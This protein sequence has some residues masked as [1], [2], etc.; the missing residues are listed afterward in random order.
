MKRLLIAVSCIAAI[1]VL[2][3]FVTK[4]WLE[5]VA[6]DEEFLKPTV[7]IPEPEIPYAGDVPLTPNVRPVIVVSGSD[8][9]MGYQWYRQ[10]VEIYGRQPLLERGGRQ[11]NPEEAEALKAWQW[12]IK[13]YTPEMENLLKGMVSAAKDAGI[14]MTYEQL[15][16]KWLPREYVVA[17]RHKQKLPPGLQVSQNAEECSDCAEESDCS[18]F[19]AWG[20]ATRDGRL[21]A[22]GSGDHEIIIGDNEIR[23]FEYMLLAIPESGNAYILSTSTGCCWHASMNN[24]GVTMF[25]HGATGYNMRYKKPE[26]QDFGYGVPNNMITMHVLRNAKSAQEAVDLVLSLPSPDDRIGGAWADVKGNAFVVE[27]RNNPRVVRKA[28]DHGERDF[29]YST[30]NNLSKLLSNTYEESPGKPI[31]YVEFAGWLGDQ[32]S[33]ESIPRNLSIRNLLHNYHGLVDRDFAEMMWRFGPDPAPRYKS[34]EQADEDFYKLQGRTW[35]SHIS[36]TGNAM[37]GILMPDDGDKGTILISQGTVARQNYPHWPGGRVYRIGATFSFYQLQLNS[38]P[39]NVMNDS[40]TRARYELSYAD[41][42][43]RKL[44]YQDVA[45]APLD[46]IFNE[47]VTEWQKGQYYS[48]RAGSAEGNESVIL[49]GKATRAFARSQ[50]LAKQV[51]NSLVAPATRP[52]ELGLRP[53]LG[54]WGDWAKREGKPRAAVS[55]GK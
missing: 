47:A 29:I 53:W 12:H 28:G 10:I 48:G 16:A 17:L 54:A 7:K 45:Y 44:N 36:E 1:L 42:E 21:I 49:L 52:E 18:G 34:L 20:S 30:N 15:L 27:S 46:A 6:A 55:P 13:K 35:N 2:Y 43:L 23:S 31:E 26:E 3:P 40:R 24:K 25:H 14:P 39:R 50:A 8:Y 19:A 22:G 11:F 33:M 38:T 41:V 37:V 32:G 5:P 4:G 51:Y 9:D